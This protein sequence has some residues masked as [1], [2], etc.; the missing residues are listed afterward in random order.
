M[1]N[2]YRIVF[3]RP[4]L[5]ALTREFTAVDMHFHSRFSDG[6]CHVGQIAERC[7]DLGIGIA[8]TDHNAIAGALEAERGGGVLV[9]PGIEV[10]SA[11]GT[12]ILLYFYDIEDLQKFFRD[13]VQPY[14]GAETMSSTR[15]AM[16]Q[17]VARARDFEVLIVFPHPFSAAYTGICNLQ[18]SR[19]RR[20]ILLEAA[21]GVEVINAGN[22][23]RWNLQS[24]LLGFNLDKAITAGSDGHR[25]DELGGAVA[26]AA[27]PP[28][29][30]A[31]LDA[32]KNKQNKVIGR[33][34]AILK[35][36][37]ANS[38]KL[39][40]N[41]RNYP[42]LMEKNIRYS[43]TVLNATSQKLRQRVKDRL[44]G[45]FNGNPA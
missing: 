28:L 9:I 7:R 5:D 37:R 19:Q 25:L 40:T 10:T 2:R 20:D 12:H 3:E 39:R 26:Y 43:R 14:M 6:A 4:D 31:F 13:D 44:N 41:L 42:E 24:A 11:E 33:E 22:M 45:R 32:V 35:K 34:S 23:K 21:D 29:R 18:F 17:I 27:C 36:V 1:D 15:L 8:L 38:G 16:E 30:R